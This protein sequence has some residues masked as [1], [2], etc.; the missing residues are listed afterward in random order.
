MWEKPSIQQSMFICNVFAR[1]IRV[2]KR[3]VTLSLVHKR[4]P[5]HLLCVRK[6]HM[7]HEKESC[8]SLVHKRIPHHQ[9]HVKV[10]YSGIVEKF[11]MTLPVPDKNK[12]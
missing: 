7:C 10:Q 12:I 11:Q 2:M 3:K 6:A 5:H 9:C 1:H 4:I 8:L